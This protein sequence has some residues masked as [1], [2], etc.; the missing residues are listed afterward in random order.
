MA[1]TAP[2]SAPA[3]TGLPGFEKLSDVVYLHRPQ[4]QQQQY[5]QQARNLSA[6]PPRL[7]VLAGWM[8]AREP[9]LAKYTTRLQAMYPGS[10][11][12]VLRSFLHHFTTRAS[13][14]PAEVAAAV[15]VIRSIMAEH[16]GEDAEEDAEREQGSS[17]PRSPTMLVHVF[18]NGGAAALRHLR[19]QYAAASSS[20]SPPT[21]TGGGKGGGAQHSLPPHVTV[22]DSAPGRFQWQRSV[23]A[24]MA[25]AARMNILARLA[26][27]FLVSCMFAFYWATHVPWGRRGLVD[28]NWFALNDRQAGAAEVRR[29]Y[30]YSEE[31]ALVDYRHV[32]EH[33]A[34]AVR[35]GFLVAALE[36]FRGSAHVAHV[37]VDEARYWGIIKDVWEQNSLKSV[38]SR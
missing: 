28:R 34:L 3:S 21:A 29:A 35:D 1:A 16:G 4:Q 19:E 9:H 15:P 6:S 23:T 27:R 20:S 36:K 10:P 5:Q 13:S 8:G 25:S 22:Y 11:I 26:M 17:T 30:I 33:A 12:L 14:H 31:D 37:R 7:I 32:E 2:T 24:F 38:S 18:S